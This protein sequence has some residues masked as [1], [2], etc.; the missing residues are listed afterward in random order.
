MAD[1]PTETIED[2]LKSLVDSYTQ[3]D[4][5][6]RQ[7]QIL[8]WRKLKLYWEGF[9][10]VWFD[11][12]AHD[13]RVY[14]VQR[15]D[16][17][18]DE[19]YYDKP[20][21][22]F[23]AYIESIIAALSVTVP[24]IKCTPDDA[25]DP[26]D[27]STAKASD[28]IAELVYKHNDVNLLWIHALYIFYTEGLVAAYNYSK[29]DEKYGTYE[30]KEYKTEIE[31]NLLCPYCNTALPEEYGLNIIQSDTYDA[32]DNE[33][34]DFKYPCPN[35]GKG[36]ETP[37][38]KTPVQVQRLVGTTKHPKSR[39]CIEVYGGLYVK[40]PNYVIKQEDT[41]YLIFS[42]ET[43]YTNALERY[44][45]LR[46]KVG[47]QSKT[48]S[49]TPGLYD[50]YERW[51]RLSTQ[52]NGEYP[53]DT[54]TVRNC[55]LRPSSYNV[56]EPDCADELKKKYPNGCKVV[57][58]NE[59][60][61]EACDECLDD[62][63]TLTKNPLSDYLHHDPPGQL[64]TSVQDVT[65]DIISLVIQTIE[66]GIPQTFADPAVLNFEA[67]KQLQA[68][69]GSIYKTKPLSSDKRVADGFYEVKTAALSHEV[70]PFLGKIQ[71]FGQLVSG[72]L[73]SLFGGG[74]TAGSKT[75]AEYSMS[76]N[77]AQQR[78][79]THWK[80]LN[81]WWKQIFG[82]V[83]PSFIDDMMDD[84]RYVKKDPVTGGYINVFIRKAELA[85][86][87][88]DIELESSDQLPTTWA[89]QRDVV[90]QLLQA[91]NPLVMEGLMYAENLPVLAQVVGLTSF[92]I[93]GE[94]DRQKQYEEINQLLIS[95]P[96]QM[97]MPPMSPEMEMMGMGMQ[98]QEL[99]SV[100][101]DIL[102]D[103][104]IIEAEICKAWAISEAGRQAKMDNPIGYKNVLLHMKEHMMAA[105]SMAPQAPMQ[106]PEG[107]PSP[108]GTSEPKPA[109]QSLAQ[110]PKGATNVTA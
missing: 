83:I 61:A 12:V 40:V 105:A 64:L 98:P 5:A 33:V 63:W 51:G 36:L 20:V 109:N 84:D 81:V 24:G 43:H 106:A 4:F 72:A 19:S 80:M 2:K 108:Q 100:Q 56:L 13:W 101:V 34:L 67:Y 25:D 70:L 45:D 104:H 86:R 27:L 87:I 7:R 41:P 42:Y 102:L 18:N 65:N 32:G 9:Q 60:F 91:G 103:D 97:P 26:L 50:T 39:Q 22:V 11:E 47:G 54:V 88:G 77:Q 66:H 96:I 48:G 23:R 89:Q 53:L 78:L 55:W 76:R 62:H 57:M 69:P 68:T 79:Q 93:P 49:G 35:C 37:I 14:D 44:P 29:E 75:A 31:E 3:D 52:Y 30:E 28:R 58:I 16:D 6:V 95:E 17:N 110:S 1:K 21:N 8:Q 59:Y 73:P 94:A 99:P 71:E 10:R 92:K 85:G 107:Q 74:P 46:G 82:K 90:M 38:T 15:F